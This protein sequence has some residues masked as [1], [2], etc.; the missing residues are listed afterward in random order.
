MNVR[1]IGIDEAGRG[2][3]AGPLVA[4]SVELSPFLYQNSYL[5]KDSKAI[6]KTKRQIAFDLITENCKFAI[7]FSTVDEIEEINIL[8]ATMLAMQ[9]S[10]EAIKPN[11]NSI[12]LIDGNQK[13]R[14]Q[15]P[16]FC[17]V[18][19]DAKNIAIS[20]AS[21]VAKVTR[22]RIM[23]KLHKKHPIYLWS[24]NKGYPT[25]YHRDTIRKIGITQDHRKKFCI[26]YK[27][28]N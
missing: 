18:Q 7:G 13:P 6:N 21:I 17:I 20:A 3:L 14:T 4:C 1:I 15:K 9:R 16:C 24:N 2:A 26:N 10:I 19:G 27:T 23:N 5:M 8:N 11:N 22:D 12:V 28:K 25:Q